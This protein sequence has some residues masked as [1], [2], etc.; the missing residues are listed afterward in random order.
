MSSWKRKRQGPAVVLAARGAGE[1]GAAEADR[2][3]GELG[4]AEVGRAAVKDDA[5]EVK[6]AALP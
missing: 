1:L 6:V 5:G 4:A 3:A 2:A